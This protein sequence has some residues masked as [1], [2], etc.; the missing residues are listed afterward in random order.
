MLFKFRFNAVF[1][2]LK[3]KLAKTC[4][5]EIPGKAVQNAAG[6]YDCK[7]RFRVHFFT[8]EINQIVP[9]TKAV[10][11]MMFII[12][13]AVSAVFVPASAP[14]PKKPLVK[15]SLMLIDQLKFLIF[16]LTLLSSAVLM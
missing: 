13:P 16:L 4:N 6:Y 11:P 7:N 8:F 12:F 9:I 1:D 3:G 10:A 2:A 5:S 14:T 15:K